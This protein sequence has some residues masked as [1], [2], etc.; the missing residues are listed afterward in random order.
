M[1]TTPSK[2]DSP[3]PPRRWRFR[4]SLRTLLIAMPILAVLLGWV[5]NEKRKHDRETGA[6]E[7]LTGKFQARWF[8]INGPDAYEP[9]SGLFPVAPYWLALGTPATT[10][11]PFQPE[12]WETIG[13]LHSLQQL[14]LASYE[15]PA[16]GPT[17]S[18][19]SQIDRLTLRNG[20]LTPND[21][22]QINE[23]PRLKELTLDAD[24]LRTPAQ[25]S[26]EPPL[27]EMAQLVVRPQSWPELTSITLLNIELTDEALDGLSQLP[28]LHSLHAFG[29]DLNGRALDKLANASQLR[30]LTY[31]PYNRDQ[32]GKHVGTLPGRSVDQQTLALWGRMPRLYKLW[33]AD[34]S[35]E[36]FGGAGGDLAGR[37]PS[38]GDLHLQEIEL[39]ATAVREIAAMPKLTE[40]TLYACPVDP[41]A[42]ETLDKLASRIQVK[43]ESAAQ[44]VR[45]VKKPRN[46]P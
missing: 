14:S 43:I 23:L 7:S 8:V 40:L 13:K 35:L 37:W 9:K 4:F 38:L 45:I 5:G 6:R 31:H 29:C 21:L 30:I 33:L 41:D 32:T 26:G 44:G 20:L 34:M 12:D 22:Q 1:E 19:V 25:N 17:F 46:M 27:N 16:D 10:L 24:Y 28:A 36:G 15:G 39:S 11:P 18:Q 42:Q 3:Q 2:P